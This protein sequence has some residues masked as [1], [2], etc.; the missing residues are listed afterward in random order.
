M[1]AA[2]PLLPARRDDAVTLDL[3]EDIAGF[4]ALRRDWD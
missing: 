2:M 1:N 3:V 4:L